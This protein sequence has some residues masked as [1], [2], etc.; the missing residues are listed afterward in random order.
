ME[1]EMERNDVIRKRRENYVRERDR[2][3]RR[4]NKGK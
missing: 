2:G 3:S 1:K 4:E